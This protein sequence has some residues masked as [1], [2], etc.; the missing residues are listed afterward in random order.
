MEDFPTDLDPD[1]FHI[2][3][4]SLPRDVRIALYRSLLEKKIAETTTKTQFERTQKE[5]ALRELQQLNC[6]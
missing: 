6:E 2:F 3:D 4:T 1:A 5:L